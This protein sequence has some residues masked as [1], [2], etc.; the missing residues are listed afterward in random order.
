MININ[1]KFCP[2][3]GGEVV[4]E[5][6]MFPNVPLAL[7]LEGDFEGKVGPII[8][9]FNWRICCALMSIPPKQKQGES[10]FKVDESFVEVKHETFSSKMMWCNWWQKGSRDT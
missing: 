5:K 6:H 8:L 9:Y 10:Y 4:D 2:L 3:M 7:Q 1:M